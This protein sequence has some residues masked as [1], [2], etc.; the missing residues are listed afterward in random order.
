MSANRCGAGLGGG[1]ARA[2]VGRFPTFALEYECLEDLAP[3][4]E[5]AA[6]A[7]GGQLISATKK[8]D[9]RDRDLQDSGGFIGGEM[10]FWHRLTPAVRTRLN[11][12][13][14]PTM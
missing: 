13:V 1:G 6:S 2:L 10:W 3:D 14:R 4:S 9:S 12:I 5:M 7:K 11:R 8:V